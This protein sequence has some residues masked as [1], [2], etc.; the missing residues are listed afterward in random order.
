GADGVKLHGANGYLI[1]QFLSENANQRTDAYGGS[2]DHRTRFAFEVAAGVA[3]EIGASRTGIRLSPGVG[4]NDLVE[5]DTP[6][7]YRTLIT[8]LARLE[9]AYVHVLHVGDDELLRWIRPR[10]PTAVI[11]NRPGRPR[12]Q[13]STD[14]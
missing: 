2:L 11:V 10:W 7:L 3:E 13:L 5:G 6:R 4:F 14:V 8:Q 1:H 9:L 12:E